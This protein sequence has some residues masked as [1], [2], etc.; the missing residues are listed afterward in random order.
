MAA[1]RSV[2]RAARAVEGNIEQAG[3]SG[4]ATISV[5]FQWVRHENGSEE[6]RRKPSNPE[7]LS[8]ILCVE[9]GACGMALPHQLSLDPRRQKDPVGWVL[10]ACYDLGRPDR[11]LPWV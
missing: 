10:R 3:R 6:P 9:G 7:R 1:P 5:I 2:E 11:R 4:R 8:H